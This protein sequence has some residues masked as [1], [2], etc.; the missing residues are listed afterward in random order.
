MTDIKLNL[1]SL[2][3]WRVDG[4]PITLRGFPDNTQIVRLQSTKSGIEIDLDPDHV[5]SI[6]R[7][8]LENKRIL[9]L[10]DK[11][12]AKYARDLKDAGLSAAKY[13]DCIRQQRERICELEQLTRE[14]KGR[15][16]KRGKSSSR[17][18]GGKK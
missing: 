1:P 3:I 6:E 4:P 11:I 13:R 5:N 2:I 10:N 16:R 8:D 15:L 9:E 18:I 7:G 12:V 17:K 14:L